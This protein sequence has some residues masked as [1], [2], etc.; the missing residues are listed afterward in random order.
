MS[1]MGRQT[2]LWEKAFS[3]RSWLLAKLANHLMVEGET[4]VYFTLLWWPKAPNPSA[5]ITA[6]YETSV[7]TAAHFQ[8]AV[9][10]WGW[11]L[12]QCLTSLWQK[13]LSNNLEELLRMTGMWLCDFVSSGPTPK[14][15][16]MKTA[17]CGWGP[18]PQGGQKV[19]GTGPGPGIPFNGTTSSL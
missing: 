15:N 3:N 6:V 4:G 7:V 13:H 11:Q 5:A 16:T 9:H 18:S 8:G 19:E 10:S 2:W 12:H 17:A 1:L 14:P